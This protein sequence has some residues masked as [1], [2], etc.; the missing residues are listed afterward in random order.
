MDCVLRHIPRTYVLLWTNR[1]KCAATSSNEQTVGTAP[2]IGRTTF[3]R[4]VTAGAAAAR[5]VRVSSTASLATTAAAAAVEVTG[6]CCIYL[7]REKKVAHIVLVSVRERKPG[8]SRRLAHV[9]LL[10]QLHIY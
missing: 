3:V 2:A 4:T 7:A 6:E 10:Q 8:T 5:N 1:N 9:A